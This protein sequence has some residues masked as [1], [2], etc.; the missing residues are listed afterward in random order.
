MINDFFV[1]KCKDVFSLCVSLNLNTNVN[2]KTT[3]GIKIQN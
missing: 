1:K 3:N 2:L